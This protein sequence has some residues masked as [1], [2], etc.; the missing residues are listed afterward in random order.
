MIMD[1]QNRM[2]RCRLLTGGWLRACA[3]LGVSVVVLEMVGAPCLAQ[4][5]AAGAQA[6]GM[7]AGRDGPGDSAA[8][9]RS[10]TAALNRVESAVR[11]AEDHLRDQD[12]AEQIVD[13]ME[14]GEKLVQEVLVGQPINVRARYLQAR[15]AIL[16]GRPR[17]AIDKIEPFLCQGCPG[18]NDWYAHNL[19]GKQYLVSYPKLA[20]ERFKVASALAPTEPEPL[21]N[22][23]ASYRKSK[24]FEE[25]IENAEKAIAID[26]AG[27]AEY[28]RQLA[29]AY[30]ADQQFQKA[31]ASAR[32][33][34][35]ITE[36]EHRDQPGNA[37]VLDDLRKDYA[38]LISSLDQ[39]A[40][41]YRIERPEYIVQ[42]IQ[43][44]QDRAD[45]ERLMS[46]HYALKQ[47]EKALD[48]YG[49][50]EALPVDLLYEAARLYRVVGKEDEA[51]VT[52][53]KFLSI[54]AENIRARRLLESMGS[55]PQNAVS[56]TP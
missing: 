33:A 35:N 52:I 2:M 44:M 47:T 29:Q 6:N 28:R 1:F 14:E 5:A 42:L 11:Y 8:T 10:V 30:L 9:D 40:G 31:S 13:A 21:I 27:K 51:R 48:W 34:L 38:L 37:A 53:D 56:R 3:V 20:L 4:P 49:E 43:A 7:Q 36:A 50:T 18:A 26:T 24:R 39:L 25:A 16:R 54:D 19:L 22:L 17:E 23:S 45:L 55:L 32:D 46:Y 41:Q 15:L 12:L